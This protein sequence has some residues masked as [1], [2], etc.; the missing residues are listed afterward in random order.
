M[1]KYPA[2]PESNRKIIGTD[3]GKRIYIMWQDDLI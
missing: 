2:Q 3:M 1:Y